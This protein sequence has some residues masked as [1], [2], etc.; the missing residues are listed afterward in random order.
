MNDRLKNGGLTS[1][2][3]QKP[4]ISHGSRQIM[5]QKKSLAG[6]SGSNFFDRPVHERLHSAAIAKQ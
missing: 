6:Q 3:K 1:E 2:A 5:E 4:L